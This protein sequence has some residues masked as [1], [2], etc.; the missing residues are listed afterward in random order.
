MSA[1]ALI[2]LL[3]LAPLAGQEGGTIRVDPLGR[4]LGGEVDGVAIAGDTLYWL[5]REGEGSR[6]RRQ[7]GSGAVV[8]IARGGVWRGVAADRDGV[9]LAEWGEP[10]GRLL[11]VGR[12]GQLVP[13][14]TGLAQPEGLLAHETGLYGIET[15][16]PL[17]P[18]LPFVP[19]A[20]PHAVLRRYRT[21]GSE[22]LA[23][24]PTYAQPGESDLIAVTA[25][26]LLLRQ[27]TELATRILRIEPATGRVEMLLTIPGLQAVTLAA[28]TLYWTAPSEEVSPHDRHASV[29]RLGKQGPEYVTDWLP[30]RVQ[31]VAVGPRVFAVSGDGVWEV[32][33]RLGM[34][35]RWRATG[36]RYGAAGPR[37]D[38]ITL[39]DPSGADTPVRLS[40]R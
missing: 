10:A 13:V 35:R 26:A 5:T 31:L 1:S 37:P 40:V 24:W 11:R 8:E 12:D 9:W 23:R 22:T 25:D 38:E 30:A 19:A 16:P 33:T 21:G 14:L 17:I 36:A 7:D 4:Q 39:I 18:E 28:G 20:G 27:A 2:A 15:E 6:L 3:L 29:W 34:P 32:P